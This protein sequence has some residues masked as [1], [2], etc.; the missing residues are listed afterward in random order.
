MNAM[1]LDTLQEIVRS[2]QVNSGLPVEMEYCRA[3]GSSS[4]CTAA[5]QRTKQR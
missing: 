2:G 3:R 1:S 4:C 5:C